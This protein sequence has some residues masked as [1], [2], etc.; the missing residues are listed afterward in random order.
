MIR[1]LLFLC[2][3]VPTPALAKTISIPEC[4]DCFD[5]NITDINEYW[6]NVSGGMKHKGSYLGFT[7]IGLNLHLDK[8]FD[9]VFGNLHISAENN[10]GNPM[11]NTN[12]R[13]LDFISNIENYNQ[14]KLYEIFYENNLGPFY[15]KFG[16]FDFGRDFEI[17]N[18]TSS[19]LNAS[20]ITSMVIN[21]NT[22]NMSN[23]GPASELGVELRYRKNNWDIGFG[24][25]SDNPYRGDFN[26]DFTNINSDSHGTVLSWKSTMFYFE[27]KKKTR[28]FGLDGFYEV[29][30]FLDTGK[31][32]NT[33]DGKF[34]RGN[35]IIYLMFNQEVWRRNN[36]SISLFSR[37][38]IDPRNDRTN[39]EYTSDSGVFYQFDND[40]IGAGFS[41]TKPNSKLH[42]HNEMR[43]ELTYSH[44][45]DQYFSIQPNIQYI[46]HPGGTSSRDEL[47]FG[48]RSTF[49]Y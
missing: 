46:I 4:N 38:V 35:E 47:V 8:I 12:L 25:S 33:Y 18:I 32:A 13:T 7:E 20:M 24:A 27:V 30:G 14:T 29:G 45:F 6:G 16:K 43:L 17:D 44:D 3:L 11:S 41:I 9:G 37:F 15:F 48:M 34:H 26:L 36:K 40:Y 28:I 5:I 19:F 2:L 31:Q 10:R 21:N 49:V 42:L 1:K 39:I 22:F 23:Y